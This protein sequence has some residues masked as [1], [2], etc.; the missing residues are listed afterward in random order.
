MAI[1]SDQVQGSLQQYIIERGAKESIIFSSAE[2]NHQIFKQK[3]LGQWPAQKKADNKARFNRLFV[4]QADG[5]V[6]LAPESFEGRLRPDGTRSR[7]ISAYIGA[8][9]LTNDITF[10][11][12]LL[13][14]YELL[15]RFAEA[16]TRDYANLY[17]SMP[18]NVNMVYWPGMPWGTQASSDLDVNK[19]EWV[20]IASPHNNPTREPV[21]TGLYYDKTA[22]EWMVSLT[23]PVDYEGEHLINIGHDILLNTLF[24][25][26]FN[27]T[28]EGAY[29]F[30]FREDGRVIAHPDLVNELR[31]HRGVL[32]SNDINNAS[33]DNMVGLIRSRQTTTEASTFIIED[34]L[35]DALLAVTRLDGPNW[36]FI[37][38]YPMSLLSSTALSVA[39]I[40]ATIGFISLV[41][42]LLLFFS[43]L[44][45]QVLLPIQAFRDFSKDIAKRKFGAIDSFRKFHLEARTDEVGELADTMATMATTIRQ[46]EEELEN[47]VEART[48]K[49][50][51]TNLILSRESKEHQDVLLLLQTIAKHVSGL[52]GGNYFN[53]LSEFLSNSLDADFVII[54][55]L[56]NDR[57]T[58]HTLSAVLHNCNIDN[59]SYPVTNTPCEVVIT[60]GTQV[61]NGN[62]QQ[63][64]PQDQQLIKRGIHAYVGT[65]MLNSDGSCIGHLAVMKKSTFTES[66]KARLIIDSVSSRAS[67]ELVRQV[68]E[69]VIMLQATTDAL[70]ELPNRA[71]FLAQLSQA[72][73]SSK[74]SR[75][76]LAV[77]YIDLDNFKSV[78][79][80]YGH[81]AGDELLK[82][83]ARRLRICI[84]QTDLAARMGGDEF[85]V[86]LSSITELNEPDIVAHK[87]MDAIR[88]KTMLGNV[89][90]RP[91][92]SIGIAIYPED[93]K[94]EEELVN[95]ADKA[96]YRAKEMGKNNLQFFTH[97]INR[98][99]KKLH[100]TEFDLHNAI[101]ED[102]FV[103]FYQPIFCLKTNTISR[104]EAF[105]RWNH[106]IHGLTNPD[107][108]ISIAEHAGQISAI[109]QNVLD[110]ICHDFKDLQRCFSKL[111]S[112]A[113][114]ISAAQFRDA[115]F[116]NQLLGTLDEHGIAA[117]CIEVEVT[118]NLFINAST[119]AVAD[120]INTLRGRGIK[121]A[122]DDFGTGYSPL[123]YLKHITVDSLKIDNSIVRDLTTDAQSKSLVSSIISLADNFK[124]TVTA[125]GVEQE[126]QEA[127][128]KL[129]GCDFAQG[130]YYA[131][132]MSL[133]DWL[134]KS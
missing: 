13:L 99:L 106:P 97:S 53:T 66:N 122:L 38:V 8:N 76:Q 134:Q 60:E 75:Q 129:Q 12:K 77:M 56:S 93:G 14:S 26:V 108:F 24:N 50:I 64:F 4:L 65:P 69:E 84:R 74:R 126:D 22:D 104:L 18:E 19:E 127:A 54:C 94:S 43:I 116:A 1:L 81:A 25:R 41:L 82:T 89:E 109:G 67:S 15:D 39:Y 78:N 35:S 47:L 73:L 11:N 58:I 23:T 55:R 52:Q 28:L 91:S 72:I 31:L 48:I 101:A 98:K 42:E 90:H 124:L 70:T 5:T 107:S 95:S 62:V 115:Q 2:R 20:Y 105:V 92:C 118:E 27:D 36:Y 57:K 16:W 121:I 32:N 125:E 46:H 80:N 114:N 34:E 117:E 79:D 120:Q 40:V 33:L 87:I 96:M 100:Q 30:I 6:A 45:F 10:N 59:I 49:L 7:Y 86:M 51:E 9:T 68:N 110:S 37:T 130:Y 123:G 83:V 131:R 112:I 128:L 103:N 17:V 113:I 132:P 3:F 21:W 111:Q 88:G 85:I 71:T 44:R 119:A 61:Y 102:E 29:N 133:A 63:Q